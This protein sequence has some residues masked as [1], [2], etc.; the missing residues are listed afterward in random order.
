MSVTI[1]G[2]GTVTRRIFRQLVEPVAA[3][4]E[5]NPPPRADSLKK[6]D[7]AEVPGTTQNTNTKEAPP[8][9]SQGPKGDDA[10]HQVSP[11]DIFESRRGLAERARAIEGEENLRWV[12]FEITSDPKPS[13]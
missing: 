8:G 7:A 4:E 6:F 2:R 10:R 12:G 5:Y 11:Y 9:M 3:S 13:R 1:R